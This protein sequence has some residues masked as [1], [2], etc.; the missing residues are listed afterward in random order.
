VTRLVVLAC[1]LAASLGCAA[2]FD[3]ERAREWFRSDDAPEPPVLSE[4]PPARLGAVEG[5]R[6]VSGELRSVPLRWDPVLAGDVERA[7]A[8]SVTAT[9]TTTACA[10]S[11]RSGTSARK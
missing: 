2:A 6:T 8:I 9:P 3:V 10:P 1:C 7:R 11:I 5:L 4:A